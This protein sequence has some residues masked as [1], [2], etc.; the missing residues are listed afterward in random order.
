M[1]SAYDSFFASKNLF[2][3]QGE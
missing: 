1:K 2:F 3:S